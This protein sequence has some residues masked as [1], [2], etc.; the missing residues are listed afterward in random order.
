MKKDN[1]PQDDENIFE[2]TFKVVYAVD[3]DGNYQKVPTKG[4]EPENT[5]LNQAWEVINE[6]V[7]EARQAVDKG[8]LSPLGFHME[9]NIMTPAL[10]AEYMGFSS[11]KVKK[12][13]EPAAFTK[14]DEEILKKY[15]DV[16]RI[17]VEEF[18]KTE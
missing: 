3:K 12:H 7:E 15:A 1:V 10:V 11:R 14:L 5:A 17:S 13:L 6:K 8:K 16:F 9:K 18:L 2:G 4:W